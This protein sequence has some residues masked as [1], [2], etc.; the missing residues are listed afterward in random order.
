[1]RRLNSGITYA[2]VVQRS[3]WQQEKLKQA[4]LSLLHLSCS[5]EACAGSKRHPQSGQVQFNPCIKPVLGRHFCKFLAG[6]KR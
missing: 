5:P 4:F 3:V 2:L 1:M 6:L